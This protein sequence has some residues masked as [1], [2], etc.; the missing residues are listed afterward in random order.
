[1]AAH[2][3]H[4]AVAKLLLAGGADR[5]DEVWHG[6]RDRVGARARRP[7]GSVEVRKR[8]MVERLNALRQKM[9][10]NGNTCEST[11]VHDIAPT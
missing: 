1:M 4:E 2:K 9:M 8:S 6:G 7:R 5:E 3:G 11:L 10:S